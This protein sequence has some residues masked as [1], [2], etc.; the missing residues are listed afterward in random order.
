M[1]HSKNQLAQI[2]LTVSDEVLAVLDAYART[3]GISRAEAARAMVLCC[4]PQ[5]ARKL[6]QGPVALRDVL[7]P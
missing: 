3:E 1:K 7:G 6:G 4:T 2:K 5:L